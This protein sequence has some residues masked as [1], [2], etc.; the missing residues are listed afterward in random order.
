MGDAGPSITAITRVNLDDT[1]LI[2]DDDLQAQLARTRRDANRRKM[3]EMRAAALA[4]P[5][6]EVDHVKAESDDEGPAGDDVLVLDD[7]SEFV[8]NISLAAAAPAR[9]STN[10]VVIKGEATP[11]PPAPRPPQPPSGLASVAPVI[12]AED[13]D[14]PIAE[15]GGWGS[16]REDGEES[17]GGDDAQMM[18]VYGGDDD[19]ASAAIKDAVKD[20]DDDAIGGVGEILVSKG[21]TATL[22][23]LR[24]Q[25]LLK[26]RTPEE[27]ARDKSQKEREAWLAQQRRRDLE[28]ELEK[29]R[30]KQAGSSIDQQQREHENR[31]RDKRDAEANLRAFDNYKPVVNLTYHDEFGRDQTPKEAWK[32]LSHN[33]HGHG[34]GS[35]KTEKRLKKIADEQK[36]QAMASGDTPLSTATAFAARSERMGQATMVLSVGNKGAAPQQEEILSSM[37]DKRL[38]KGDKG[39]GKASDKRSTSAAPAMFSDIPMRALPLP[40]GESTS[41]NGSPAVRAGFAPIGSFSPLP[42][43][44]PPAAPEEPKEKFILPTSIVKRKAAAEAEGSPA[45]KRGR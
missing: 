18:D 43:A 23:I 17:D 39:K 29:Q 5:P 19:M 28:R 11:A 37:P 4:N 12:K 34:G 16:P 41:R 45:S 2:D 36:Q 9:P 42:S 3:A 22:S 20:E 6:M 32:Q 26:E 38:K 35:K 15:V 24:Q 27:L 21:M 13:E 7:T 14:V 10:G 8:R 30:S 31:M 1:N 40:A 33:F 25:G 44:A